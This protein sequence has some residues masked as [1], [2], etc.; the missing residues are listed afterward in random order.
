MIVDI[1]ALVS[2][3][4]LMREREHM[5][6]GTY[7]Y[8]IVGAGTAG[9][10]IA[11]RLTENSDAT[12]L[13]V[14]GGGTTQPA[15]SANP[16]EWQTLL[17]GPADLGGLT[18]TQAGT[19]TEIHLARGRGIG[20]SSTINAMTFLRGHVESY[21][22]WNQ[23]GAERWTYDDLLPYFKRSESANHGN[24]CIRGVDGPLVVAPASPLNEINIALLTAAIQSGYPRAQDVSGGLEIGFGPSDL[25]IVDGI[26]QSAADAYL[27]PALDRPNLHLVA[28]AVVHRL[29][30]ENGRCAGIEYRDDAGHDITAYASAEV[31]LAAGGIGSPHLLMVSGIGPASHLRAA[32]VDVVL[33]LPAVGSNLQDHPLTGIIYKASREIS[34]GRNNHGEVVGVLRAAS[35]VGAPDLQLIF[36]DSAA[37]IGL[38]MPN[39]YLIGVCPCQP[40]SRGSV[41]LAGPDAETPPL[42]DPNYL[43]DERDMKTMLEGFRIAREIGTARALDAWRAEELAPGPAVVDDAAMRAFVQTTTSSY[44]HPVGTCAIGETE[45][46]VVDSE[47]RVHD[48]GGLRVVDA[49]VMPS[50]PSNNPLATVYAIAER[51]AELIRRG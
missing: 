24:P 4:T 2:V 9:S 19:G 21:A 7:D 31:V 28:N 13:L 8:I 41:R 23:F 49:S 29:V 14:E 18:T 17:R 3:E 26:R 6:F 11:A 16:P 20:G 37:V 48:I 43:R 40:H 34:A 39:T 5:S 50:L 22:D 45:Q 36:V 44:Y 47:L 25:T 46:S 10:V 15:A 38:E 35:D 33:D 42:V 27:L 51:G 30:V 12:V 1:H 32:G